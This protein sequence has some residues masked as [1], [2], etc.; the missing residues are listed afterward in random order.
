LALGLLGA[1][2]EGEHRL[3]EQLQRELAFTAGAAGYAESV[4]VGLKVGADPDD[5]IAVAVGFDVPAK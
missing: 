1:P 5:V 4:A 2:G 3:P